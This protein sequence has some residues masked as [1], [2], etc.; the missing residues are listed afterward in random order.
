[1][2]GM[3][4]RAAALAW[5]GGLA[6]AAGAVVQGGQ[7]GTPAWEGAYALAGGRVAGWTAGDLFGAAGGV[8][9]FVARPD[10]A[11]GWQSGWPGLERAYA[12]LEA[13]SGLFLA[14]TLAAGADALRAQT[15]ALLLRLDGQG[16]VVWRA[17]VGGRLKD[18]GRALAPAPKDGVYLAGDGEGRVFG[19]G[20]GGRD[21]FVARFDAAGERLWGAQWGS[22]DDDFLTAA[23]PD[24]AG[25]VYLA[26]F[27]DVDEDC[28]RVSERGFLLRY[29]ASG[30]LL[31]AYRWGFGAASR[32]AALAA[33]PG[34]VWV[35]GQTDGALYGPFAGGRD[36]FVVFVAASGE[37]RG[38]VQW[39]SPAADLAHALVR[40]EDGRLWAAGATAGRLFAEPRGAF[41]AFAARLDASGRPQAGWQGGTPARDEAL[42]LEARPDGSVWLAG[43]T[44]GSFWGEHAGQADAWAALLWLP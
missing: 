41:D 2:T 30:E 44:Y 33:A 29:A 31:W 5:L 23:A 43:V 32:P 18:A 10:G 16:R 37:P 20:R 40:D 34:G 7:W 36:V 35:L 12:A 14:G 21:V 11:G 3:R 39:G 25:G 17:R 27:S 38:G 9:V 28:R 42:A 15:D 1:M 13:G 6:L 8:D 24:G 22:D 26:G 4:W 19:P